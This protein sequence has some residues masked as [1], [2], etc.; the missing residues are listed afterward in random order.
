MSAEGLRAISIA[1]TRSCVQFL[2]VGVYDGNAIAQVSSGH[3]RCAR[4]ERNFL[5][6][7]R[8]V[9]DA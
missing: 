8:I 1:Q 4:G 7:T 3:D 6:H 5:V 2:V 9:A